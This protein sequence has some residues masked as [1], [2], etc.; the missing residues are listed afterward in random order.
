MIQRRQTLYLFA[1]GLIGV[2]LLWINPTYAWLDSKYQENSYELHYW[3]TY[4][5]PATQGNKNL[6]SANVTSTKQ[7]KNTPVV[8]QKDS[9]P[10]GAPEFFAFITCL[11]AVGS[12]FAA[13]FLFKKRTLQKK[14]CLIFCS[15]LCVIV[16]L[17]D[18]AIYVYGTQ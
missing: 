7:A 13:V 17:T 5:N 4:S 16:W 8:V 11:L 12:G 10:K 9:N 3:N 6:Q 15:T 14:V 18:L 2:L 1:L